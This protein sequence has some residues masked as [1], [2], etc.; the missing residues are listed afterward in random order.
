MFDQISVLNCQHYLAKISEELF[1]LRIMTM[2][3]FLQ[4][5]LVLFITNW[6]KNFLVLCLIKSQIFVFLYTFW[7]PV[8]DM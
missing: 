8:K 1:R 6:S 2:N 4:V 3:F 7:N 5:L